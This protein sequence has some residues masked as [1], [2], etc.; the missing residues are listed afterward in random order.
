MTQW[1]HV[2]FIYL[3]EQKAVCNTGGRFTVSAHSKLLPLLKVSV[4]IVNEFFF[5]LF[6]IFMIFKSVSVFCS[7]ER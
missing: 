3:L 6:E 4:R 2:G 5:C 1:P 7:L